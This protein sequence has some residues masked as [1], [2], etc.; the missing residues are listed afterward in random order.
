[1]VLTKTSS[2]IYE[3]DVTIIQAE[4]WDGF[5]IWTDKNWTLSY[6]ASAESTHDNIII[7][8]VEKYKQETGAE[9]AQVYPVTLGYTPGTYH[10]V[11]NLNT[12][13]LTMTSK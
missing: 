12:M 11:L 9:D 6:G 8:E 10:L 13:R 5:K 1:M 7:V 3:G 4:S 2:G